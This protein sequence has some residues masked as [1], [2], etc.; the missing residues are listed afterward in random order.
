MG[1][2]YS[3]EDFQENR[4]SFFGFY[5]NEA[6]DTER[7]R[8]C[9]IFVNINEIETIR[10]F[11][12]PDIHL[13]TGKKFMLINNYIDNK[14]ENEKY[15]LLYRL[16]ILTY[17]KYLSPNFLKFRG[18]EIK[19]DKFIDK[20]GNSYTIYIN[21]NNIES[22]NFIG[23]KDYVQLVTKTGVIF[24]ITE[25]DGIKI[26]IKIYNQI[27]DLIKYKNIYK[28]KSISDNIV[29]KNNK[30]VTIIGSSFI[31]GKCCNKNLSIDINSNDIESL[32]SELVMN[33]LYEPI[34]L[35]ILQLKTNEIFAV[36]EYKYY[37]NSRDIFK[38]L[39]NDCSI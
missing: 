22:I 21:Y 32:Y 25:Y 18:G 2:T 35:T 36:F 37:K 17:Y 11:V 4:I 33:N 19:N 15:E 27:Y 6:N 13:K 16:G 12:L 1:V 10:D 29:Q 14:I 26:K 38:K 34:F 23:N 39:C 31:D 24:G 9:N 28:K 8:P 30:I 3:S 5:I 20:F 7:C